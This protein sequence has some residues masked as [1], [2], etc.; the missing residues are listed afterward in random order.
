MDGMAHASEPTIVA[1]IAEHART[2][3][4][5]AAIVFEDTVVSWDRL[6]RDSNRAAHALRAHGVARGARVAYI[7]RESHHYYTLAVAC[8]KAGAVL[9]PCNWRLT[10]GEVQHI[11]RDSAAAVLFAEAEFMPVVARAVEEFDVVE[12]DAPGQ[13]YA[14]FTAWL[15]GRPETDLEFAPSTDEP[16]AQ[17][18][19][20]GTTGLPKGVVLAH[21]TF[22]TFIDNMRR[23]GVDWI[24]WRPED[25]SLSAF[26]GL[27]AGGYAWFM[28][29]L[30][31]GATSVVLQTFVAEDAVRAIERH[32]VTTL[33]AA[34]AMLQMMLVEPGVTRD[35]FR[36]LRKTVYGGS[37]IHRELLLQCMEGFSG[38][39]VQAYAAAET[40]SFITCL[41]AEEHRPENPKLASA[42]R[43]CPGNELRIVDEDGNTLGPNEPGRICV[44]TPAEFVE[45]WHR[46]DETARM[47]RD[48]WLYMG[49]SGY[50]DEDGYLFLRD[51]INDTIIVAG[52]N[53]YP[54]EVE[55]VIRTHPAV[56]DVAVFGV[57]HPRWGEVVHAAVV[58]RAG[59]TLSGRDLMKFLRGKLAGFKIP[60]GYDFVESLPRNPTGKV[61]RRVL[62]A[63]AAPAR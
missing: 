36:S 38:E 27:H 7:G 37:P 9:V 45:Y 48:G 56:D 34:P 51:R 62:R 3:P 5:H 1:R 15:A 20:S 61:L 35:T 57:P 54:V 60:I 18:Y 8:A 50:L 47:K 63:E 11:L 40:G 30:N 12:V 16:V 46:P 14:G 53:I 59:E 17:M 22:F 24:D 26:P 6:H 23:A 52:Q 29:C 13:R 41:R 32:A 42:G 28:H 55:D 10:P 25:R 43:L 49:D 19:T 21:R 58:T 31:A 39:L 2:R 33:W 44:R 4:G